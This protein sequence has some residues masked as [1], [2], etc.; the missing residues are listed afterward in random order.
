[1][2]R[3]KIGLAEGISCGAPLELK[4][5]C[6]EADELDPDESIL[7]RFFQSHVRTVHR[8]HWFFHRD[9]W[10]PADYLGVTTRRLLSLTD[11]HN[12][13]R[14]IGGII[15]RHCAIARV[16]RVIIERRGPDWELRVCFA[17][18]SPRRL[19]LAAGTVDSASRFIEVLRA[20]EK[21][22]GPARGDEYQ[23][24]SA[25]KSDK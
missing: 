17:A 24:G 18:A 9:S 16:T 22:W 10:L 20:R 4:F 3:A 15:S 1:M 11:R 12:E 23:R 5:A 14:E 2:H 7:I 13:R 25:T 6:A 21:V 19:P 8:H